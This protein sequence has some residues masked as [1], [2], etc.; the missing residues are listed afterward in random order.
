MQYQFV[1]PKQYNL[2]GIKSILSI[3]R[4]SGE[5]SSLAV[6]KLFG[7]QNENYLSFPIEGYTPL[8]ISKILLKFINYFQN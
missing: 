5:N 2:D 8:L 6:L 1:L 3:I 7:N 4:E